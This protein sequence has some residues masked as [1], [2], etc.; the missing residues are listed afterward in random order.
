MENNLIN[1]QNQKNQ[2]RSQTKQVIVRMTEQEFAK[3][4]SLVSKSELSKSE[5]LRRAVFGNKIIII[6]GIDLLVPEL[7]RIGNNLNQITRN[8]DAGVYTATMIDDVGLIKEELNVV[9]Q[10]LRQ[11]VAG[12]A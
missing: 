6:D 3:F 12:R 8:L 2:N 7:K 9:W 11:L 10:L 4:N 5:Y 1:E